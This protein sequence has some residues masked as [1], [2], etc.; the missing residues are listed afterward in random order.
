MA[1]ISNVI[2]AF[3]ADLT[4][5]KAGLSE[6]E[7]EVK[8]VASEMASFGERASHALGGITKVASGFLLG[9]SIMDAPHILMEM[10]DA[11]AADEAAMTRLRG[12][13]DNT[14]GGWAQ[15]GGEINKQIEESSKLGFSHE[16]TAQALSLL[17]AETGSSEDAISRLSAAQNFARGTG[18]DLT[19]ASKLLGK[20][21]DE[22]TTALA[23]YG[24]RVE[25][26]ASAQ[27]L[28]NKV[29]ARFGG[30]AAKYAET[31]AGSVARMHLQ[32][33]E[34]RIS[35]GEKLLPV[36]TTSVG[37]MN[38]YF[39]PAIVHVTTVISDLVSTG[40]DALVGVLGGPLSAAFSVVSSVVSKAADVFGHL[41]DAVSGFVAY[42]GGDLL[43]GMNAMQS[44]LASVFGGEIA[45]QIVVFASLVGDK[46]RAAFGFAHDAW[47]TFVGALKGD[48]AQSSGILPLHT[49]VGLLG[50]TIRSVVLTAWGLLTKAFAA[51]LP[52]IAFVRQNF[53]LIVRIIRDLLIVLQP[54]HT[55]LMSVLQGFGQNGF[56][57]I[58]PGLIAGLRKVRDAFL[59]LGG[60]ALKAFEAVDWGKVGSTIMSGL[61]TAL[62][63]LSQ[64]AGMI[65]WSG[66][67][68]SL[69][70]AGGALM[71]ALAD[72]FGAI[73]WSSLLSSAGDVAGSILDAISTGL[74]SVDWSGLATTIGAGLGAAWS[75]LTDAAGYVYTW[76]T[77][78]LGSVAWGDIA[79][80][81][82]AGLGAAWGALTD[83]ATYVY[84]WITTG[85]GSIAWG[86]LATSLAAYLG[87]AWGALTD[88]ATYVYT[89]ITTGLGAVAWT[90]MATSLAAQLGA[91]WGSLTDAATYIYNWI[92]AGIAGVAWADLAAQITSGLGTALAD[93]AAGAGAGADAGGGLLSSLLGSVDLSGITDALGG[94][95]AAIQPIVDAV[96]GALTQGWLTLQEAFAGITDGLSTM[97]PL[98]DEL[99]QLWANLAPLGD[100]LLALGLALLP[101]FQELATIVGAVLVVSFTVL[102]GVLQV[103]TPLIGPV[104]SAAIQITIGL[105]TA[106][107]AT[108]NLIIV[109]I[110]D[111]V[112]IVTDLINGD[113]SQAWQDAEQLVSDVVGGIL[114]IMEGLSTSIGGA[115][116]GVVS[117]VIDG[118]A[119]LAVDG[120]QA[121][122]DL[123]TN[124][125]TAL[126]GLVTDAGTKAGEILSA[127]VSGL[128]SLASSAGQAFTDMEHGALVTL[129]NL[130]IEVGTK[131]ADIITS[132]VA[133]L[134]G[135]IGA[136]AGAIGS[137]K[138]A[139]T[140][141]FSDAATWL[142]GYGAQI[143]TGLIN[144]MTGLAGWAA[145]QI[146][147][148]AGSIKDGAVNAIKGAFGISSPSKVTAELGREVIEGFIVGMD[149]KQLDIVKKASDVAKGVI[150]T[151]MSVMDFADRLKAGF[152]APGADVLAALQ[153]GLTSIVTS[154]A[155]TSDT[156]SD[157]ML[158][159]S[160][161][162]ADGAKGVL[163]VVKTGV[164]ALD[165][166]AHPASRR[167]RISNSASST[168]YSRSRTQVRS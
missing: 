97:N 75:G 9:S 23:R 63:A 102:Q 32:I 158:A 64:L 94:L 96:S 13:V 152:V 31:G 17:T 114:G 73:D 151:F 163:D 107:V 65:D 87:A 24:I 22:S 47:L 1:T 131:A 145:G 50:S 36:L 146:A 105:I 157:H 132:L 78:G 15:Y 80:A 61:S 33:E 44:A 150:D 125:G 117:A 155:A 161:R 6:A 25:K 113:W 156:F 26:G 101:A 100:A 51:A 111:V 66:L 52:V 77:T 91:A 99:S 12:A 109:A 10:V 144:G 20:V 38:D 126:A 70:G 48:W 8:H 46:L 29:D 120:A 134:L 159:A 62:G 147:S 108:L 104:F 138:S 41:R 34:W 37:L 89:W 14:A 123:A 49:I 76:I 149:D 166:L 115:I 59:D 92:V 139:I 67:W 56:A 142:S 128:A 74:G 81:I 27:D 18:M 7:H 86:D 21:T 82:G 69:K 95:M 54:L 3:K 148:L 135:G 84:T 119:G 106:M 4:A 57:G 90:D 5:F 164:D 112:N 19:T 79:T 42:L 168:S 162:F 116:A 124:A 16:Q 118:L 103:I 2:V 122:V 127:I 85:L 136:V 98:F 45:T 110:T 53:A 121:F 35:L 68:D 153:A 28:L 167:S 60:L 129:G 55:I 83:A 165:A 30:Q 133:G 93:A 58:L 154:F 40:I 71:S 137:I 140:G 88:A 39:L 11:A 43:G 130:V 72:V 141:A 143:I 160:K